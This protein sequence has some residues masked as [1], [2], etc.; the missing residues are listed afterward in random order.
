MSE[1]LNGWIVAL[2][3]RSDDDSGEWYCAGYV[4]SPDDCY[5]LAAIITRDHFTGCIYYL[6]GYENG[7]I[8]QAVSVDRPDMRVVLRDRLASRP[9]GSP[10]PLPNFG[11]NPTN[12]TQSGEKDII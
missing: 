8:V 9:S 2:R 10:F 4:F 7:E 5:E 3:P 6:I 1:Y 12:A 11:V